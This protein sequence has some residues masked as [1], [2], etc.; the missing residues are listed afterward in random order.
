MQRV[1][2]LEP[3]GSPSNPVHPAYS[4][5]LL[6]SHQAAVFRTYPFA[7]RLHSASGACARPLRLKIDPGSRTTGMAILDGA[8]VVW[9][10][11]IQH[12]GHVIT[13]RLAG[14]SMVRRSRR[15]RNLRRRPARFKNRRRAAGWLPPSLLSRAANIVTWVRRLQKLCPIA[16][17]SLEYVKFDTQQMDNP[18]IS[19][20]E[21]QQ[22]T[23]AGY[24][25]REYL[26]EKWQHKCAYCQASG[27]PL[28]IEHIQPKARGGSNRISNLTLACV[29]CNQ[30]KGAM[31]VRQFLK[32][33]PDVLRRIQAQIK[34]PMKDAAAV[35]SLRN[36][37]IRCLQDTG[38]PLE[39]SSGGVT[40]WN[41]IRMNLP[42]EHWIDAAC[43]GH[44]TPGQLQ[45]TAIDALQIRATGHG[46]RQLCTTDKFGFPLRHRSRKKPKGAKTGDMVMFSVRRGKCAGRTFVGR[47]TVRA[48]GSSYIGTKNNRVGFQSK[49]CRIIHRKDGYEYGKPP[50]GSDSTEDGS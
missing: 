4:R 34:A 36:N 6:S 8:N 46:N 2:V 41:R 13:L 17:L 26:L 30:K 5:R 21:Y 35:Q 39:L 31:D 11:E 38:L 10:C 20:A 32:G 43:V 48:D 1:F 14:R 40:K 29:T 12:R 16:A 42:K 22:G 50:S 49:N 3:D 7:I 24:E 18:A 37:L 44:S 47:A 45:I 9:A 33:R 19:G 28:Q 15:N 23:L 25:V 27:V